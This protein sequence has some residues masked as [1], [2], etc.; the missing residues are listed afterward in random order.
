MKLNFN[1]GTGIFIVI[2]AFVSFFTGFIIYSF[3]HDVNL[4][5]KDYFPDEIA[6]EST[7]EKIKNSNKLS[8][9]IDLVKINDKIELIFPQGFLYTKISGSIHFFYI[10]SYKEDKKFEIKLNNTGKQVFEVK[11]FKKGRFTIK[12][13]WLYN[14]SAYYQEIKTTL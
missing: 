1:W 13:D 11:D 2:I 3:S 4:V 10:T 12:I 8:E 14:K 6:Y 7:I 9:K 5:S